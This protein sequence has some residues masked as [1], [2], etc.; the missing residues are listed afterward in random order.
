M[1]RTARK[2]K[3][4][5]SASWPVHRHALNRYGLFRRRAGGNCRDTKKLMTCPVLKNEQLL[6]CR[7]LIGITCGMTASYSGLQVL[8]ARPGS[9]D[10]IWS[11]RYTKTT[12]NARPRRRAHGQMG[13]VRIQSADLAAIDIHSQVENAA[14]HRRLQRGL[15]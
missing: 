15:W 13:A 14:R 5:I 9:P 3:I 10:G 6:Y 11:H 4:G 2:W 7:T 1:Y 12:D 8:A